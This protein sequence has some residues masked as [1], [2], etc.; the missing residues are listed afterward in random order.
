[1]MRIHQSIQSGSYPN[2]TTMARDLEVSTKSIHRDLEFMQDRLGLPVEYDSSRRGFYY[3]HEVN[4]FPTLQITEGELFA[5]L[6]AEK[7]LQQYR[8]TNFERPLRS[9]FQK[10]ADSLPETV[11][12]H[13]ADW[14]QTISFRTSAE[15]ILDLKIF[16]ELAKATARRR[17]IELSYRKAGRQA[18]ELRIVDPYHLANINGEWFL[19]GYDHLRKDI[20]TFVPS[21]IEQVRL[22]GKSFVRLN[23]FSLERRLRGS[24]GV[25]SGQDQFDIRIHFNSVV[26][27]Y[28]RE[29]K[30]HP[31]QELI[32][33]PNGA[34][35]LRLK[36]S[37]LLEIERWVL[38]WGGNAVVLHPPD[39]R[40]AVRKAAQT[41]LKTPVNGH[42]IRKKVEWRSGRSPSCKNT[43]AG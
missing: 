4:A 8:G 26:A 33:R 41:I 15:P 39:L 22:T 12:L 29:K 5:L 25:H 17:Q 35:E 43:A 20:R 13:W 21:R 7:A 24:F 2:A 16:D 9:A 31:S 27:G 34:I 28:V 14:E 38:G 40:S 23:K 42:S 10:M 19:F 3:T 6:V 1:M 36:L 30:W 37:S 11:S 32:E 18:P